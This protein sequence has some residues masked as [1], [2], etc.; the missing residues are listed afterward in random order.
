MKADVLYRLRLADSPFKA[1]DVIP[2]MV[3]P[4]GD[5]HSAKYP[6]LDLTEALADEI[7]ANFAAGVLGREPVVDSS[8]KHDTSAPAAAWVKRVYVGSFEEGDVT[9]EALWADWELT[10]LGADDLNQNLYKYTSV[11]IGPVVM[12]ESGDQVD[13]VLRSMTLTNT[14]VLSIMPAVKDAAAALRVV[15]TLSEVT[16]ADDPSVGGGV[17]RDKL[18]DADFAGPHRSFPIVIPKDVADA[19]RSLGRAKGDTGAVKANII[20][21]AKRKGVAFVAQLPQAWQAAEDAEP[22]DDETQPDPVAALCDKLDEL[23]AEASDTLKGKPGIPAIRTLMKMARAKVGA[24]VST[25]E[26]PDGNPVVPDPASSDGSS[27]P[28]KADEGHPVSLDEGDPV[29]KGSDQMNPQTIKAL[30]LSEDA[31]DE[32]VAAAVLSLT[33]ERDTA[34]KALADEATAKHTAEIDASLTQLSEAGNLTPA[35]REKWLAEPELLAGRIDARK[36]MKANS[37]VDLAE[38]GTHEGASDDGV[39]LAEDVSKRAIALAEAKGIDLAEAMA[40]EIAKTPGFAEQRHAELA[41]R[42]QL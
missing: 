19:A 36:D 13:N 1:G 4:I 38:H 20:A 31:T 18:P 30:N 7:V 5:W 22:D 15:A 17:D 24:H 23:F 35:E 34:V 6:N 27:H 16:L 12:N 29:T 28:A 2:A 10:Q 33:E 40:V 11:E 9:G 41:R 39:D 8:G 26:D 32:A 3:F 25:T 14:P 21:I 42:I 37:I